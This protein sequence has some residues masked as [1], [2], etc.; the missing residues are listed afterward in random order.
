M[1]NECVSVERIA[2]V[3]ELPAGDVLSRHVEQCPRCSS[4]LTSYQA[5]IVADPP[6][7]ANPDDADA[8][9]MQFLQGQFG[10]VEPTPYSADTTPG[11]GGFFARLKG[12]FLPRPAW[13]AAAVVVVAA[14]VWWQ[15]WN[16]AEPP[17]L[18]STSST[19]FLEMAPPQALSDGVVRLSWEA[20]ARADRYQVVLY[21]EELEEIARL[22]AGAETTYDLAQDALP[23]G[24]PAVLICRIAALQDGDEI[25][26]SA[27]IPVEIP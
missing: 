3:L 2:E 5:F 24:A 10:P 13:V 19:S 21:S 6:A 25:A 16:V 17:A 20:T 9:L 8:R 7:G 18:R 12:A 4:L 23:A 22:D 11:G 26:E 14:V 27:P 1:S 15:P